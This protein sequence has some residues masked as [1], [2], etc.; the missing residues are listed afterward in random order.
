MKKQHKEHDIVIAEVG[1]WS[2]TISSDPDEAKAAL[3][4]CIA[5]L[6]TG[7]SDRGQVLCECERIKESGILGRSAQG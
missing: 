7:R 4:K 5:G 2:N 6:A 1:T 3:E